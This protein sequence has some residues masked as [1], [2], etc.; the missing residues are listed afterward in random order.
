MNS[1]SIIDL[2]TSIIALPTDG[3]PY[4]DGHWFWMIRRSVG[5]IISDSTLDKLTVLTV[6]TVNAPQR[7]VN[8]QQGATPRPICQW[9]PLRT[10]AHTEL[11]LRCALVCIQTLIKEGGNETGVRSETP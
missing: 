11:Q 8:D 4:S 6:K 2:S 5:S 9:A 1:P 3:H 10:P 7:L